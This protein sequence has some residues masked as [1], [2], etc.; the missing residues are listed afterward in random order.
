[1]GHGKLI[2]QRYVYGDKITKQGK[3]PEEGAF[4]DLQVDTLSLSGQ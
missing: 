3:N 1:M 2:G 4:G